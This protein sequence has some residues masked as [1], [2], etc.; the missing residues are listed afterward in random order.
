M[1]KKSV[2]FKFFLYQLVSIIF[3][4]LAILSLQFLIKHNILIVSMLSFLMI[5]IYFISSTLFLKNKY[6][7]IVV[8]I[9][10]S[11]YYII[12][13][14]KWLKIPINGHEEDLGIGI[15]I[16]FFNVFYF[17]IILLIS[18]LGVYLNRKKFRKQ[19]GAVSK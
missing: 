1:K 3:A 9:L 19:K 15:V 13:L 6:S 17:F 10:S 2:I 4:V 11:I 8:S 16:L 12:F 14:F 7:P 5:L 18:L